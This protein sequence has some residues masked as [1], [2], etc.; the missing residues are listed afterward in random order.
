MRYKPQVSVIISTYNRLE[1]LKKSI[2]SV[3]SQTFQNFEIII[4]D[5]H[6]SERIFSQLIELKKLDDRI[7]ILRTKYN[8]GNNVAKN[9]GIYEADG[10][11]IAILDDDDIALSHR[12]ATQIKVF[13]N[14]S[15][16]GVVGSQIK[17]LTDEGISFFAYPSKLITKKFPMPGEKIFID[18]YLGKYNIPNSS[19]MI[20]T[21]LVKKWGYPSTKENGGDMIMLLKIAAHDIW[22][23]MV[24]EP[25]VFFRKGEGHN[26][27]TGST[28]NVYRGRIYRNQFIKKWLKKENIKKYDHLHEI[29]KI[30]TESRYLLES[31][32]R[33]N[34]FVILL[35]MGKALMNNPLFVL[36]KLFFLIPQSFQK[37]LRRLFPNKIVGKIK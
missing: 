35:L 16:I 21:K 11:Y 30:N 28:D 37:K 1:F 19:L 24:S 6:S 8:S 7:N 36:Y 23:D 14:D 4:I 18:I 32:Q 20:R 25:L 27:M 2:Q 5:D 13:Q 12:L 22:F 29:A 31:A 33:K 3:L 9:L 15:R 26:Q 34:I 17:Y 10:E